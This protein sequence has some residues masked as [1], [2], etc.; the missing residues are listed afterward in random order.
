[1]K[2]KGLCLQALPF[3]VGLS[4]RMFGIMDLSRIKDAVK[5]G[6]IEWLAHSLNRMLE[7]GIARDTVKDVL[8]L[9]EVIEDYPDDMPYP[10]ALIMGMVDDGPLHVVIAYDILSEYCMVVTVY[11]PDAEHFMDDYKTRKGDG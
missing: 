8:V 11:R 5:E 1:M 6:R 7:R 3:F 10:S 4:G 2:N 9:C